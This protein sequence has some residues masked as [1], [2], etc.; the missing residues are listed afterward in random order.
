M[1]AFSHCE[2]HLLQATFLPSVYEE[3]VLW[4][5]LLIAVI[6]VRIRCNQA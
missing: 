3:N 4:K 1:L 2:K 6:A 5:N